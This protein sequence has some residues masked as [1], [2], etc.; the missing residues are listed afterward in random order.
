MRKWWMIFA[1][2]CCITLS[3][4]L[5]FAGREK[6]VSKS[7]TGKH[8][9]KVSGLEHNNFSEKTKEKAVSESDTEEVR[10]ETVSKSDTIQMPDLE[11]ISET[12]GISENE[13]KISVQIVQ[14]PVPT[15]DASSVLFFVVLLTGS[16]IF[17]LR[18][19]EKIL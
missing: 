8:G 10:E 16:S 1:A 19:K 6:V 2:C 3:M 9:E 12:S 11:E 5:F 18:Y 17:L 13:E 14:E 4:S 15:G 7:D